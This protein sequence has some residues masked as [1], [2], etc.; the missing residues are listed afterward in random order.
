MCLCACLCVCVCVYVTRLLDCLRDLGPGDWQ[1]AG[2]VCQALWNLIGGGRE[3]LLHRKERELLL[4]I[5]ITYLGWCT[6]VSLIIT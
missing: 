4:Q 1:L 3:K 2:Q 6:L 5:L